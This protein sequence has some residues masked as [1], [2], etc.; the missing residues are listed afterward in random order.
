MKIRQLKLGKGDMAQKTMVQ[1][2]QSTVGWRTK[3]LIVSDGCLMEM[4]KTQCYVALLQ[5]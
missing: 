5:C 2:S 3:I 4:Y 1:L